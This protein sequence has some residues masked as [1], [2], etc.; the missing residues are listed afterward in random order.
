MTNPVFA[1]FGVLTTVLTQYDPE[2]AKTFVQALNNEFEDYVDNNPVA[3]A[4]IDLESIS[5]CVEL[6]RDR[7]ERGKDGQTSEPPL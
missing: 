5:H 7:F 4:P 3:L 6:L 2:F 1:T